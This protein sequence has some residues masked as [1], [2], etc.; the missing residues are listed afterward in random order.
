[1][2]CELTDRARYK[3]I[4][5]VEIME[6]VETTSYIACVVYE[7]RKKDGET[8]EWLDP[9]IVFKDKVKHGQYD[10]AVRLAEEA[11]LILLLPEEKNFRTDYYGL[12]FDGHG[13]IVKS[14]GYTSN[15]VPRSKRWKQE[16]M[17][18]HAKQWLTDI[19]TAAEIVFTMIDI[20]NK[21]DTEEERLALAVKYLESKHVA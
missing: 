8:I 13:T 4:K 18:T 2:R 3:G 15:H 14:W 10:Q 5:Q 19:H 1:M 11:G 16:E 6:K 21:T 9:A 20:I 17:K 12:R 7:K